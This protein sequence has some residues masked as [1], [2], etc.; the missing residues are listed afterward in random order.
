MKYWYFSECAYP[1][2]PPDDEYDSIRVTLPNG[3]MDPVKAADLWH[4]YIDEWQAA[5]G[6]GLG[7]MVNEHHS[8]ATCA[9]PSAPIIAGILARATSTARILILG[10]PIANRPDP[11]RVAEEMALIDI[12]S[13]GRLECGFVRGVPYEISATNTYPIDMSARFWEAHDLIL[14]A[15]TTHDGPFSWTGKFFEHRQV[16]IW[17]RPYQQPRPPVWVTT[18]TPSSSAKI[19]EHGHTLATFLVGKTMA[20]TIFDNYRDRREEMGLESSVDQLAYCGLVFVGDS[21]E[22][23]RKG[24]EELMWY[25]TSNKVK[26]PFQVPSGYMPPEARLRMLAGN[27]RDPNALKA[28]SRDELIDQAIMFSGTP[29][30]VYN[31]I[32]SF[33]DHVGGFGNLLIMGQAGF[34]GHKQTVRSMQL[35]S[36]SVAPR[37][38]ALQP[39]VPQRLT[40]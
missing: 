34:L 16:N 40:A 8:T 37:L 24:A 4:R 14:K 22:E 20:K 13:R 9:N 33:Y 38:N 39:D 31:Q 12:I 36:E 11:V 10:N 7:L 2:L 26:L 29:D 35:F 32:K 27:A 19:A 30:Q 25:A 1:F 5:E 3:Y 6:Y 18:T 28:F 21:E 23:A 15:W 17:P